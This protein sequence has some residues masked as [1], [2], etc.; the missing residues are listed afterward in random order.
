MARRGLEGGGHDPGPGGPREDEEGRRKEHL[1]AEEPEKEDER[2][3]LHENGRAEE[4]ADG[5]RLRDDHARR[6]R[7]EEVAEEDLR[8]GVKAEE[9]AGDGDEVFEE[10]REEPREHREGRAAAKGRVSD[11]KHQ[12]I[13]RCAQADRAEA[14]RPEKGKREAH[15]ETE[16]AH[17][18][19][20]RLAGEPGGISAGRTG[21]KTKTRAVFAGS[22]AIATWISQKSEPERLTEEIRPTRRS[23]G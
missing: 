5:G 18:V 15:G 22:A 16:D 9:P 17:G 8:E 3:A 2:H 11:G 14:E 12:E 23:L 7:S 19:P 13:R 21:G 4:G 1:A 6:D 10:P 20:Y